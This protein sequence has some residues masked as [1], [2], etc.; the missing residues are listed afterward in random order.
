[1]KIKL[2]KSQ[3][4]SAG[5]RAGWIKDERINNKNKINRVSGTITPPPIVLKNVFDWI[6][7][8]YKIDKIDIII[9]IYKLIDYIDMCKSMISIIHINKNDNKAS[10]KK[11]IKKYTDI[12]KKHQPVIDKYQGIIDSYR[13]VFPKKHLLLI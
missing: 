3:W 1:M 9:G 11:E 8:V 7:S 2:S 6:E 10:G 5:K 13:D 12:I 4:E